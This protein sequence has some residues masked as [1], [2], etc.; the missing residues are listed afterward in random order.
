MTFDI[1]NLT[2]DV[3]TASTSRTSET[4]AHIQLQPSKPTRAPE[5]KL[6][7]LGAYEISLPGV[8]AKRV[9]SWKELGLPEGCPWRAFCHWGT[10]A[11]IVVPL[12][13]TSSFLADMP[14][15]LPLSSLLL[16]GN[17]AFYGWPL[18]Q[19][20]ETSSTLSAQ[21]LAGIRVIDVRLAAH[22]PPPPDVVPPEQLKLV[23]YHGIYPQRTP[24]TT[25]LSTLHTFLNSPAGASETVVMSLKQEDAAK[26]DKDVWSRLVRE[27]IMASP[28]GFKNT[29]SAG[30][31]DLGMWFLENR[32]PT[33]GEVRGKVVLFSRFNG[34]KTNWEGGLSGMGIH[35]RKWPDSDRSGFVYDLK[36]VTVRTHDWCVL[37][38]MLP[39]FLAI[40]EKVALSTPIL[41]PTIAVPLTIPVP[42]P[43]R[44]TT[45]QAPQLSI[46]YLSAAAF[47][48]AFPP[49]VAKGLG[50][51]G[52]GLGFEGVNSRTAR[53]LMEEIVPDLKDRTP[54]E[55]RRRANA[56]ADVNTATKQSGAVGVEES[57]RKRL[58]WFRWGAR[59]DYAT[60]TEAP[61]VAAPSAEVQEV[62]P[63]ITTESSRLRGWVLLDYYAS[64]PGLVPLLIECN[65]R[66]RRSGEEGWP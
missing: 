34:D 2:Q 58:R 12:R 49:A 36:G 32:I 24:F 4:T 65:Y 41:H 15:S 54:E 55:L 39:S 42:P 14:D 19:C 45:V 51:P 63:A 60:V 10:Q 26:T 35:P 20:Q 16:P 11:L 46:T 27:E 1:Y 44:N 29:D 30:H 6:E 50:W 8:W 40:P 9:G 64:E 62:L 28:G 22:L 47:P 23:A 5:G 18:S 37:S 52:W 61:I 56:N 7:D 38:C 33:L 17:M 13:N 43:D 57:R 31:R 53:W 66:A 25:I 21:L 3:I 48:L 59:N